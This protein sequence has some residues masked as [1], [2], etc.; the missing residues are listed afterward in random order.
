MTAL[1]DVQ[2]SNATT[3][4]RFRR[5]TGLLPTNLRSM[6]GSCCIINLMVNSY[7]PTPL[8]NAK[9]RIAVFEC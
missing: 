1:I 4:R 3:F 9:K 2:Q 6:P 8:K 7:M 5:K